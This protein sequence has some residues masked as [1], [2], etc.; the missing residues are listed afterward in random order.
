MTLISPNLI[1]LN[2]GSLHTVFSGV[3]NKLAHSLT[4]RI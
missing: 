4:V 2:G 1:D 3:D